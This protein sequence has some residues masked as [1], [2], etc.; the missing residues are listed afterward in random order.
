MT[1]RTMKL[2]LQ[3]PIHSRR[4]ASASPQLRAI[5]RRRRYTAVAIL[6]VSL[7]VVALIVWWVA[8]GTDGDDT[9]APAHW[10]ADTPLVVV[11]PTDMPETTTCATT[12]IPRLEPQQK[13][14]HIR[15][16]DDCFSP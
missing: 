2:P 15:D 1:D 16:S 8:T 4:P 3:Q 12:A 11:N 5:Y 14:H 10:P 13:F 9:S 6:L 7:A